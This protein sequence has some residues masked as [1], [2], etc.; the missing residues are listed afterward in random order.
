MKTTR[1]DPAAHLK[2][3]EVQA[4]LIFEAFQ[5][6]DRKFIAHVLGTVARARGMTDVARK[7]GLSREALY[8]TLSKQGDSRLSA[9]TSV[10]AALKFSLEA[11]AIP[12]IDTM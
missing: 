1:L 11:K 9:L 2:S 7:S 5:T 10:L 8:R 6:G 12:P 4:E 3:P